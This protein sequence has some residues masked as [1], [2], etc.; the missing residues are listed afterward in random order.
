MRLLETANSIAHLEKLGFL[1][2]QLDLF[3]KFIRRPHGLILVTGPTGSGKSTTLYAALQA[4]SDTTKNINTIEDPVEYKL[5]GINQMQVNHKIDVSFATGLRTLVRQDPDVILVGEIRD[6]ETAEIAIQAALTGHLVLSTLHTNDAP[7]AIIRL[8]NMGIERFLIS[9]ALLGVV[10]QRLVRQVCPYCSETIRLQPDEALA[11]GMPHDPEEKYMAARG[12]GCRRCGERGM[13]GR[14]AAYEIFMMSDQIRQQVL[15][16]AAGNTISAQ[17]KQEGMS[18]M[19]ESA[20]H[21][22]KELL[23]PPEELVRVFATGD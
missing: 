16:G 9:S 1:P 7:G 18:T 15:D 23:V 21:K 17:A 5:S 8:Q 13:K 4:I 20:V 11:L 12:R 19:Y 10:G 14:T 6:R 2:S 22:V 3:Q